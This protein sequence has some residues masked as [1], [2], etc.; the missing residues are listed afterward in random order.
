MCRARSKRSSKWSGLVENP[1]DLVSGA[2]GGEGRCP[3][4]SGVGTD[5]GGIERRRV[6]DAE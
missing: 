4:A 3:A 5:R 2:D 1:A 6:E